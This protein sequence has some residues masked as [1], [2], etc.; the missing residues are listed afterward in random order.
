VRAALL[1]GI[2]AARDL[3]APDIAAAAVAGQSAAPLDTG[4]EGEDI[5]S[6]AA[7][8]AVRAA[9][10]RG[11]AALGLPEAHTRSPDAVR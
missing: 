5:E 7:R 10:A 3:F 1:G 2:H 11:A 4:F 8:L 6:L 9:L